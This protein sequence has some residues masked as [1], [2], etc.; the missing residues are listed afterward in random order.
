MTEINIQ[1]PISEIPALAEHY[2]NKYGAE[3]ERAFAHAAALIKRTGAHTRQS[4]LDL[5]EIMK[6]KSERRVGLL[7]YNTDA[8]LFEA[9]DI[10]IA[11]K[12]QRTGMA[13]LCGLDG[14]GVPMASAILTALQQ[15]MGVEMYTVIDWQALQALGMRVDGPPLYFYLEYLDFCFELSEQTGHSSRTIDR[16]LWQWSVEQQP[17]SP[18]LRPELSPCSGT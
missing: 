6:W 5:L 17:Q 12:E 16:A 3:D 15:P 1:F 18:E 9:L 11:A 10:A 8:E 2:L 4:R 7:A 14:V 13:V